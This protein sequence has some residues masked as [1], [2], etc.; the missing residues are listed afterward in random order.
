MRKSFVVASGF[1]VA[2]A[3]AAVRVAA[4][5]PIPAPNFSRE[6][7]PVIALTH[8]EVIDGTGSAAQS[9]QTVIIEH[10]KISAVGATASVQVPSGARIIDATGKT[11]IPGL[12]GMHEHLFYPAVGDGPLTG[13][14]QFYSFPPL[15]LASGVTTARTTGSMDPYGDL[16]VTQY[17]DSGKIIGPNFYL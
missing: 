1:C 17:V 11:V 2:S 4:Q 15:Y 8:V 16:A 3:L 13:V 5:Q 9:D 10:G 14:E 6:D 7:A 12:V